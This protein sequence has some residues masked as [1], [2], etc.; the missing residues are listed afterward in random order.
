MFDDDD[1]G[2]YTNDTNDGDNYENDVTQGYIYIY[3]YIYGLK[4][5]GKKMADFMSFFLHVTEVCLTVHPASL[6]LGCSWAASLCESPHVISLT[7]QNVTIFP[8][9]FFCLSRTLNCHITST[10][11]AFDLRA[12]PEYQLSSGTNYMA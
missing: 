4:C 3:I 5:L 11:R 6:E 1:H 8:G 7:D 10:V 9:H 12:R 2:G